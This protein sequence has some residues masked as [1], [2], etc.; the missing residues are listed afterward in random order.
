MRADL[1]T[2]SQ[3]NPLVSV[4]IPAYNAANTIM[5]AVESVWMQDYTPIEIIVVDDASTDETSQIVDG[6][7][8]TGVHLIHSNSRKGPSGARNAAIYRANG[9]YIAFLD[10][11]DAWLPNK[12]SLQVKV[13]EDNPRFSLVTCDTMMLSPAGQL[14]KRSHDT[15]PPDS[16]AEAWKTLL[17]YNFIP[18]PTVLARR[19]DLIELG[20]FDP[21]LPVGEDLDMWIRLAMKGEVGVIHQILVHVYDRPESLMKSCI[22]GELE[23]VLPMIE[24]YLQRFKERLSS[25]LIQSIRGQRYFEVGC[26][27]V[28]AG[29]YMGSLPLFWRSLGL[30][31][32]PIKSLINLLRAPLMALLTP[33]VNMTWKKRNTAE[34]LSA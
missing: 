5:R 30:G 34:S 15:R 4:V 11:D 21:K 20:G 33:V 3:T 24:G 32:R 27:M 29:T 7:S 19:K 28:Y 22:N 1:E 31:Y 12:I 25:N 26:N 10:A 2:S 9:R 13:M 14:L 16:G 17:A 23:V 18:T 8:G 6:L